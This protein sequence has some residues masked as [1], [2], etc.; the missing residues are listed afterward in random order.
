MAKSQTFQR[1]L[2][3]IEENL[4]ETMS[5]QALSQISGYSVPQ[6]YRLFKQL[7]GDTVNEYLCRRKMSEAAIELKNSS[8]SISEIAFQYG[9]QSHDVFTRAFRRV[10]GITPNEYRHS[11]V[12]VQPLKTLAIQ[13]QG[14]VEEQSQ[15]WFSILNMRQFQVV[16]L[17]CNAKTWDSDG[18]IESVWCEFLRRLPRVKGVT[19][20]MTMYGICQGETCNKDNFV[21]MAAVGVEHTEYIPKG[22]KLRTI[23]PQKFFQAQVPQRITTPEAYISTRNY[24]KSLGFVIECHD[25][26]EVYEERFQDPDSNRFRLLIPIK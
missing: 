9:F 7:T 2:D 21:Y 12:V 14:N 25:E 17:E 20:P 1:V 13:Q 18:T 8:K 24:A 15:M 11:D 6:F 19:E 23:G 3:Y 5:L 4:S 26:L 16:G 10:Y 22:M